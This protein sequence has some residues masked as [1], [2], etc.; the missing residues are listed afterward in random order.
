MANGTF[1][2][3]APVYGFAQGLNA[4]G[5]AYLFSVTAWWAPSRKSLRRLSDKIDRRL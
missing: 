5:I 1:G 4:A 2:T 3:L